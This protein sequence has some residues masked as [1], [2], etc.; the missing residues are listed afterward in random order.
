MAI[1]KTPTITKYVS[2]ATG[3]DINDKLTAF[4]VENTDYRLISVAIVAAPIH[5][6]HYVF[7]AL[8]RD[9]A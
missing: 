6:E 1:T 2:V 5:R 9:W 8:R 7:V 3:D 4:V